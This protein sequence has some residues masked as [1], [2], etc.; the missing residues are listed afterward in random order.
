MSKAMSDLCF[1]PMS[2]MAKESDYA[3]EEWSG[4]INRKPC[5]GTARA[6]GGNRNIFRKILC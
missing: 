2:L 3:P 5:H 4:H 6:I 1:L